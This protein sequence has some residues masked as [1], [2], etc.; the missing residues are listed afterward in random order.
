MSLFD[1]IREPVPT[2]RTSDLLT[3]DHPL[4]PYPPIRPFE[5]SLW[6]RGLAFIGVFLVVAIVYTSI[7]FAATGMFTL[8]LASSAIMELTGIIAAYCVVVMLIEKRTDPVELSGARLGGLLKGILFGAVLVAACMGVI[9]L[10]GSYRITGID[11]GYSWWLDLLALGVVAGISEELLIRGIIFRLAEEG[12]G[13]W[14]AVCFSALIF[15]AMH[16]S[17]PGGTWWVALAIAIE[18]GILF[19]T[20]YILTR[21]L[22]WCIGVHFAWNIAEGPVF[23][24][25]VSGNPG[26]GSFFIASWSGPEILTGGGFGMEA[27]IVPVVLLGAI[28]IAALVYAH[29]TGIMVAPIW[30]RKTLLTR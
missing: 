18:A 19:A 29:V 8:S 22:W 17:N 24:S 7:S 13:S 25:P 12:L 11:T 27:S 10:F 30:V 9:A 21:S 2:R 23:G 20:V 15:G 14:G 28:G 16:M 1:L 3:E 26:D 5:S 4:R 6:T